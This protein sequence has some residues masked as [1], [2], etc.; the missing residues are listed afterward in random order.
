MVEHL[1]IRSYNFPRFII[2]KVS[3]ALVGVTSDKQFLCG[4]I[5]RWFESIKRAVTRQQRLINIPHST[6]LD[7]D[8]NRGV[9]ER[10]FAFQAVCRGF[11][12]HY[13]KRV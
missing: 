7:K 6:F 13:P 4:E 2:L 12:S 3:E 10:Y 9:R 11:K 1:R 5:A 8:N